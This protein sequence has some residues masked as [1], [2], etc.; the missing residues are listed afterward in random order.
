MLV[1][2]AEL[3]FLNTKNK[4]APTPHKTTTVMTSGMTMLE[5]AIPAVTFPTVPSSCA[6]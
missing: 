6:V 2:M 4:V 3:T 1:L 5:M